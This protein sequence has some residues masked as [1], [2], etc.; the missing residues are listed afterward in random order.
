MSKEILLVVDALANEKGVEKEIVFEA[1]EYALATATRKASEI[2]MDVKVNIDR[3]TGEYDTF[4][5]W[6][7]VDYDCEDF[8]VEQHVLEGTAKERD[9][10]LEIGDEIIEPMESLPFGR[11]GAQTAKQVIIQK[12]R[13]AERLKVVD[14][15]QT[16][17][18][19]IIV[20]TV[21]RVDR[22]DVII[23]L[24]DHIEAKLAKQDQIPN[25][26]YKVGERVKGYLYEVKHMPRGPQ[27]F[28]SRAHPEFL[29]ELFK[30]EVPE[31]ADNIIEI[32]SASRD[33]GQRAKV[34]VRTAD[35]R[36]DPI[37]ACIGMRGSRV[38]AVTNE[39][40]GERVDVIKWNENEAQYVMNAMAPAEVVSI[41]VDEDLHSM[42]LAISDEQLSQ[43]IGRG[44][45]NV[46]LASELTGWEL[47]VMSESEMADK[48][49]KETQTLVQ[50]F[51][52]ALSIDEELAQVLVE[53]GFVSLDEVAYVPNSE[54]L[55]IDGFD[56]DLVATLKERAKD[57]M[58]TRMIASEEIEETGEVPVSKVEGVSAE[59]LSVFESNNVKTQEDLAELSV[60]ELTEMTGL[61]EKDAGDLIMTARAPWFE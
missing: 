4:R 39:L 56:E 6:T 46:R 22:G 32:A 8:N 13:E 19:E 61:S 14:E 38:Q 25:E 58:L 9:P 43:A 17:I 12:L 45:Q 24:G 5:R 60:E 21:K 3:K 16:Q 52:E 37:G 33:P 55:E 49:K 34:S 31:V 42:D 40:S 59:M 30:L 20:G 28:V 44:G 36:L 27:L 57:A 29:I 18:G 53:E 11:I 7:V 51:V 54:M 47:N 1:V 15:Y 50:E 26:F 2:D 23:D 35:P 10:A 48:H 41:M